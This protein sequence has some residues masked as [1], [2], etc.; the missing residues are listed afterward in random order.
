MADSLHNN[1]WLSCQTAPWR[2]MVWPIDYRSAPTHAQISIIRA[3]F[4]DRV[5]LEVA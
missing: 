4:G 1:S 3:Y 2:R 5:E